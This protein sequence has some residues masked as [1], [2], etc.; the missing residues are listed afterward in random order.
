[1]WQAFGA[2]SRIIC[3]YGHKK[4][5]FAT[6]DGRMCVAALLAR[7]PAMPAASS[8]ATTTKHKTVTAPQARST[9]YSSAASNEARNACG[10]DD[11]LIRQA[12][13]VVNWEHDG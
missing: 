11:L 3:G 8:R 13:P 12:H 2:K 4:Q 5:D 1:M 6:T 7:H 10:D 9:E